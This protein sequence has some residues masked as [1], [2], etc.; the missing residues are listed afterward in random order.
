RAP[1][2]ADVARRWFWR[3]PLHSRLP[4]TGGVVVCSVRVV[5]VLCSGFC[6]VTS[7]DCRLRMDDL[8]CVATCASRVERPHVCHRRR[9]RLSPRMGTRDLWP[10]DRGAAARVY[11]G[12]D[13]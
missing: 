6:L 8:D 3:L 2:S 12:V 1:R 4:S 13:G 11:D 5:A 7:D 10:D 9:T